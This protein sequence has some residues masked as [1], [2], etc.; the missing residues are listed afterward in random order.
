MP[1]ERMT[2]TL[3]FRHITL[4]G[5]I[6]NVSTYKVYSVIRAYTKNHKPLAWSEWKGEGP[7]GTHND[8]VTI[9]GGDTSKNDFYTKVSYT[10]LDAIKKPRSSE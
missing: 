1:I 3:M 5:V 8:T 2:G 6:M 4:A 7:R 9:T 10:I